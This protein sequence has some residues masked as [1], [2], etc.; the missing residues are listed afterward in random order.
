M[1]CEVAKSQGTQVELPLVL[2]LEAL[3]AQPA[4]PSIRWSAS[5]MTRAPSQ[6]EVLDQMEAPPGQIEATASDD[7]IGAEMVHMST[8]SLAVALARRSSSAGAPIHLI[9]R[10]W[11]DRASS[12]RSFQVHAALVSSRRALK[13][14]RRPRP[15][16]RRRLLD[17]HRQAQWHQS[18]PV[19]HRRGIVLAPDC[20]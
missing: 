14:V 10:G 4:L 19:C 7:E 18:A 17:R 12:P 6:V 8:K 5:W 11:T 3:I 16:Q 9:A 2:S 20:R 15:H 1:Q 13:A